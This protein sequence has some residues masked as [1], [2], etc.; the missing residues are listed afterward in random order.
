MKKYSK[1]I[2]FGLLIAIIAVLVLYIITISKN[3]KDFIPDYASGVIDVNAIKEDDSNKEKVDYSKGSGSVNLRF[4]N[5]VEVSKKDKT[6][7][8]YFKN[9]NTSSKNIVL[10]LIIRQGENEIVLG[11]SDIIPP[12]YAIYQINLDN[13]SLT[14]GGYKGIMKTVFYDE[15]SNAKEIIDSEIEVSIE[16]KE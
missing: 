13:V 3:S 10:Y 9:P 4:S 14:A 6:A 1:Y 16:V 5:V 11:S 8:L 12:G 15:S 7:K 2:I